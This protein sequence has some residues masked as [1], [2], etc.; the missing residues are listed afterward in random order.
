[1]SKR[2]TSTSRVTWIAVVVALIIATFG[3]VGQ[4]ASAA[5]TNLW[6]SQA[7]ANSY[8]ENDGT[9]VEL[10]TRFKVEQSGSVLGVRF[11]KAA[12]N[13]G[14]H[15]GSLWS[16]DGTRLATVTFTNETSS[17]WQSAQFANK[18]ALKAGQTYTVSY[19]SPR[20]VYTLTEGHA[21]SSTLSA[22][23]S[24]SGVYAYGKTSTFPKSTWRSSQYWVD[25]IFEVTTA[26]TPS[27]TAQPSVTPSATVQPSVTPSATVRPSVTPS[28]TVQ[29]SAT[30][31]ATVTATPTAQPTSGGGFPDAS[32]TGVPDGV[33][34]TNYTGTCDIQTPNL[35]IENKIV[36]CYLRILAKGIVIKNSRINGGIYA[37]LQYLPG[38]FTI[39][40]S[41]VHAG[42]APGT[43][44]GDGN[45]TA[46]R[47][48]VTGGTRSINCYLNCTVKDSYVHGQMNDRSGVH[49][50]SGIRVNTRS[51]LIGNTIA[52]DAN[53]YPPDA[54][55]SAAITGYGDFDTVE[56]VLIDGNL[57]K[58]GS[59]GYCSY[60]GSTQGKPFSAGT[61]NIRFTNN[62]WERGESGKCGFWGPIT[63]FDS[64]APG[65]VWSNNRWD[66]GTLVQPAN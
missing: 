29:P 31:S 49:H 6:G 42:N 47:V 13:T 5:S 21:G 65:N 57:I 41:E 10:G 15:T 26:S 35:V 38:S 18:V 56:D 63:S 30:P 37:D 60:G 19:F 64:K 39:T 14:V 55:C 62:V 43:G 22:L 3:F 20:G 17:G 7:P 66:D 4:P 46:T 1:M 58:A 28:A 40:D 33:Q 34:L 9:P 11:Y 48:E 53:D 45:F 52:C 61:N 12:S 54:G 36:N 51:T 24:V 32:N 44:I 16:S 59:G 2:T 8:T 27:A 50:E 23:S 25:P